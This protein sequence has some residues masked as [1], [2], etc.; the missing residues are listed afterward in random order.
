MEPEME[1][2][3]STA[4]DTGQS[5]EIAESIAADAP[6]DVVTSIVLPAYNE[7]GNLRPLVEEIVAVVESEEM[8]AYRPV[9]ILIVD[10]GST[11]GTAETIREL[12]DE[13]D[14]VAGVFLR[15]NFGQSAALC[16]GF[17]TASGEYVVPMDAD[18]QNNPVDVPMLLDRLEDGYDCV[19]GWRKDRDDP[20][21]KTIPSGIQTY[22]AR[23]TGPDIHDFG[24][25]LKAYR[26]EA[27]DELNLRGE[28]HR[29]IPAKLYDRGY[30]ITEEPV[31]HRPRT[32]GSTKYGAGRLVRG[33]V[34]LAFNIFWNKYS[35]RPMHLMGGLGLFL[36]AIGGVVGTHALFMKYVLGDSLLPHLPRLIF[37]VAL[38]IFGFQLLMFGI[39]AE[40]LTKIHYKGEV[41]YRIQSVERGEKQNLNE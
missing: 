1:A 37:A 16:A 30:K 36:L 34:D 39:M 11:D 8:A 10:D 21:T 2:E 41:P 33:F 24:C 22:L 40:M 7:V 17:D 3:A 31:D 15:R 32:H 6:E 29:Y 14:A 19:S 12:T 26:R 35:M 23:F 5:P 20:I 28:G 25:T 27:V 9:E 38:I 13:F 18:G 4:P